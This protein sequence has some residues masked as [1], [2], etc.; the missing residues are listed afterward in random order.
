M[1]DLDIPNIFPKNL[2]ISGFTHKN[3]QISKE[4]EN[5]LNFR[6]A[7]TKEC[8]ISQKILINKLKIEV[9]KINTSNQVHGNNVV[10]VDAFT[11]TISIEA[12]GMVTQDKNM[13]LG[14]KSADCCVLLMFDPH[15]QAI[16]VAHSGRSGTE[17]NIVKNLVKKFETEFKSSPEDILV[18]LSTSASV[19]AYEVDAKTAENWT[20]NFKKIEKTE[21]GFK[22]FLDIKKRIYSQLAEANILEKNIEVSPNCSITDHRYQSYRRDGQKTKFAIGFI[23][24]AK[25]AKN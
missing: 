2:I 3:V 13:F 6:E 11:D 20:E 18:Y 16:G 9:K 19:D 21:L 10:A 12:D 25:N 8:E 15:K 1:L 22:Y 4:L 23:G 24:W 7:D 14:A 5:G 17:K